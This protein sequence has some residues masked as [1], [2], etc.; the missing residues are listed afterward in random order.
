[1][2]HTPLE[3]GVLRVFRLFA[4]FW[5]VLVLLGGGILLVWEGF[6]TEAVLFLL[7]GVANAALL[8]SYLLW[9]RLQ[10]LLRGAYLPIAI[11]IAS[12]GPTLINHLVLLLHIHPA[13]TMSLIDTWPLAAILFVPLV[14]LAWQHSLRS[15]IAFCLGT[16]LL[17]L[18]LA[19]IAAQGDS[20][21]FFSTAHSILTRTLL[22]CLVGYMVS[23][24]MA[25]QRQQRQSLAEANAKLTH[26]ATTLEQLATTRERNRLA[27]DLHD[28]LAHTLSAVAVELEA[29]DSLWDVDPGQ[30]RS[31]LERS[32]N[33]TRTGLTE[34]RRALQALRSSPL[35]DLG[36]ALAV[37]QE[38]MA[39]AERS[40]WTLDL[41]IPEQMNGLP[42]GVEQCVYRVAQEA[43]AN[44]SHH[45]QAQRV[46]VGLVRQ[47]GQLTLTV[48]D[49]GQGFDPGTV[50]SERHLG[51]RGM[52]ERAEMVG[53]TLEIESEPGRGTTVRL[54]IARTER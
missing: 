33:A 49:D 12:V 35:E 18:V 4:A 3:S 50:D 8:L 28:T 6:S 51:I 38:A 11:L 13:K 10:R 31:L 16:A 29:V 25:I 45:A 44:A 26:Y 53:S 20:Y 36:L 24:I 34:T 40:N 27:R 17:D 30:A 46:Q 42:A 9:G 7:A 14:I 15:V 54:T 1:M 39:V 47:D 43:L 48:S 41:H 32:L 52:Q 2:K 5:L 23:R 37:R 19:L 21:F 22:F